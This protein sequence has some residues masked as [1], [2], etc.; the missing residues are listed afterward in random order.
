ML[1]VAAASATPV[2]AQQ[3]FWSITPELIQRH[4]EYMDRLIERQ[5]TDAASRWNGGLPDADGLH[6]GGSAAA[7]AAACVTSLVQPKSKHYR[8]PLVAER[9]ALAV[10]FLKRHTT[11]DGNI[12]LLITNFNSPPDTAFA[13]NGMATAALL[14]RRAGAREISA[15]IE[16]I[17]RDWSRGLVRG[18]IHTP[19]HRWVVCSAL[20]QVNELFPDAS[21]VRRID[22]W[23]AEGIDIDSDGQFSERSTVVY[24]GVTDRAL[25]VTAIKLNRPALLDPVRRNLESMLHLIDPGNEAVTAISRRQDRNTRGGLERYWLALR[26]LALKDGNGVYESLARLYP[27]SLTDLM[28]YPELSN[29]GPEPRPAPTDYVKLFP[30]LKVAR[31]RRG[32]SSATVVLEGDSR[33]V[34]LRR[35]GAIVEAVRFASAFFGKGQFVPE[36]GAARDGVYEMTQSLEGP[37][38]Q[39]LEPARHVDTE[40]WAD[41]RKLRRQTE[42]CRMSY[43]ATVSETRNGFR[44]RVKAE[45]TADVPIAVEIALR[46]GGTIEGCEAAPRVA[47]AWLLG[48]GHAVFRRGGDA[49]RFGPGRREHS[50]IQVRGAQE[51]WPG[52]CVYLT[53]YTPFDHTL[54]FT[55]A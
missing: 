27:A 52:P 37:Y 11:G 16:P 43:T 32:A 34:T 26:Y 30:A 19:N 40:A 29:A 23:L 25:T 44:V 48:S 41:V 35:G 45:G 21:C 20:A 46:E 22:Q 54:D 38:Y 53:G 10:D 5:T 9:L 39:P 13:M 42:V 18:G 24:N 33:F 55:S 8:S 14:A 4:D 28:E 17:V 15:R 7:V 6:N 3:P 49:L 1:A 47:D 50:Y 36:K 51:K 2:P 31:I 12:H